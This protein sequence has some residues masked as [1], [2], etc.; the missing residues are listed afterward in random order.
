MHTNKLISDKMFTDLDL[1]F[2]VVKTML[3]S[4]WVKIKS[5]WNKMLLKLKCTCNLNFNLWQF[6]SGDVFST[7][8]SI[9]FVSDRCSP[10]WNFT[11]QSGV[12]TLECRPSGVL[13]P[14][15]D[16]EQMRAQLVF[17]LRQSYEE[18]CMAREGLTA[19]LYTCLYM[20]L[21][22]S[23]HIFTH[24]C[25]RLYTFIYTSLHISVHVFTHL[26]TRLDTFIYTSLHIKLFTRLYTFLYMSFY[27]PV[28]YVC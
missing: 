4:N 2:Q 22:I 20:S 24:F 28:G 18:M 27:V 3:Q 25:T 15:P 19:L 13:P 17:K 12:V 7:N 26:F 5:L 21:H 23:L 16:V 14:H 8:Q 11:I 1:S 6:F 10:F 9:N